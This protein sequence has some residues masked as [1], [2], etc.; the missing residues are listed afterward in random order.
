M[1]PVGAYFQQLAPERRLR[2]DGNATRCGARP[3]KPLLKPPALLNNLHSCTLLHK[4]AQSNGCWNL[5]GYQ[6]AAD[7]CTKKRY[8]RLFMVRTNVSPP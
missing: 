6:V 7:N 3:L 8:M 2:A 4:R 5:Q 1:A